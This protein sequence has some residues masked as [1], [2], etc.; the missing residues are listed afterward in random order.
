[1]RI[2]IIGN[3][4]RTIALA[5]ILLAEGNE[6][7]AIPG[8]PNMKFQ[9]LLSIPLSIPA[10]AEPEWQQVRHVNEILNLVDQLKPD[11]VICLHVE[12]S[13]VGLVDALIAQSRG[14]YL[15]F[16]VHQKASFLETSKAYGISIASASGLDI[17]S[18]EVVYEKDRWQWL[19]H[20][21]LSER[22]L[23]V[24][25]NGL[26]GGRG[27]IFTRN[28]SELRSAFSQIPD[29]DIIVQERVIGYEVALSVLCHKGSI[30]PLNVNF[31]YKREYDGDLGSNTPGM[32]T[33]ARS[34]NDLNLCIKL[35]KDLPVA[36][37]ALNYHGPLDISFI[38]D[39]KQNK[40]SMSSFAVEK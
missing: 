17:P 30:L 2:A 27:T 24:K 35:L 8:F 14:S 3:D 18:T 28:I 6:V 1:M 5:R 36:L 39:P 22:N 37:D 15:V 38:I 29:G 16:G 40:G 12:S 20:Q 32:G 34:V 11:L 25:A 26:A 4:L 31:E 10:S 9:G 13:D 23:V 7:L 21:V 33:V 19:S